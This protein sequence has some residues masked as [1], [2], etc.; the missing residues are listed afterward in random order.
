MRLL[1]IQDYATEPVLTEDIPD[2]E[3]PF[4]AILSHTWDHGH[5]VTHDDMVWGTGRDKTG[6]R[7]IEFCSGQTPRD[8]LQHFWIDTCCIDKSNHA[9]D[10]AA[11]R[12]MF[13]W[14]QN[15]R[16]CYAYLTDVTSI[17][18]LPWSKWWTRGWTLQELLAPQVVK[19]FNCD[20]RYLGDKSSL[21][22]LIHKR[23]R[24][25]LEA[26]RGLPFKYFS[27]QERLSWIGDRVTTYPEDM[28]NCLTGILGDDY[29][30]R[31][32]AGRRQAI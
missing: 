25:P 29:A 9:E 6:W 10:H 1:E 18:D 13:A 16:V 32:E 23:T 31:Y 22:G 12:S 24:I 15:A 8:G 11:I 4:Y 3:V 21:E 14:Y 30:R 17:K 7:K 28:E 19:F 26:L 20:G 2:H 27:V 5:E